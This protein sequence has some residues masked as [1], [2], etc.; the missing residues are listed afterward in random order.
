MV[1]DEAI[2]RGLISDLLQPLGFQVLEAPDA[3]IARNMLD[4]SIDL[5]ILD[6]SMPGESGLDFAEH[7]RSLDLNTPIIILSA[8]AEETHLKSNTTD[9]VYDAYLI[10]PMQNQVLLRKITQLLNLV[11]EQESTIKAQG[12]LEQIEAPMK[13]T[14]NKE[15]TNMSL[16]DP[17]VRS[18]ILPLLIELEAHLT[19]GYVKGIKASIAELNIQQWPDQQTL[20]DWQLLVESYQYKKL[21]DSIKPYLPVS[22]NND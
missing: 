9:K 16:I 21:I 4:G 10:K 5:F 12:S 3:T 18:I 22:K 17:A 7:I 2:H 11:W 15:I 1:D 13:S 20:S 14:S 6:I 19:I 8:D